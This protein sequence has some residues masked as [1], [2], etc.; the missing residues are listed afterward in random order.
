[1]MHS[2]F[3]FQFYMCSYTFSFFICCIRNVFHLFIVFMSSCLQVVS[4]EHVFLVAFQNPFH[5]FSFFCGVISASPLWSTAFVVKS[6]SI[7]RHKRKGSLSHFLYSIL[8]S[9][10]I[11]PLQIPRVFMLSLRFQVPAEEV[12]CT[13]THQLLQIPLLWGFPKPG[14]DR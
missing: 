13:H 7:S 4:H 14:I 10:K 6:L 9:K 11:I 8:L 1:M 5:N 3:F 12:L 2:L